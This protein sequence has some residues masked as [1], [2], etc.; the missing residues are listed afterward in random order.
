MNRV[1]ITHS[2]LRPRPHVTRGGVH[3]PAYVRVYVPAGAI[4]G[5]RA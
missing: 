2:P 1:G 4:R 3:A 5:F